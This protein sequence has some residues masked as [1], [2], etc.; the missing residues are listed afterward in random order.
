VYCWCL[1]EGAETWFRSYL[2]FGQP[3][4]RLSGCCVMN[5]MSPA[6]SWVADSHLTTDVTFSTGNALTGCQYVYLRLAQLH[7]AAQYC[8]VFLFLCLF[9]ILFLLLLCFFHLF[10]R[11]ISF[12]FLNSAIIFRCV[13][14]CFC[15]PY[16]SYLVILSAFIS[17]IVFL[18]RFSFFFL[19]L[20]YFPSYCLS[21]LHCF[22]CVS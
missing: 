16:Y 11:S 5:E 14:R 15:I 22:S 7:S 20:F 3:W 19:R 2:S 13:P 6:V 1:S 18:N 4:C 17:F 10:L 8:A 12:N 9:P 21:L